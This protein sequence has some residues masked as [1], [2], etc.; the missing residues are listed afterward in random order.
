VTLQG[1]PVPVGSVD[2]QPTRAGQAE[3]TNLKV[4]QEHR[5]HGV[6]RM[7]INAALQSV[8]RQ[9]L[10]GARLEARPSDNSISLSSLVAMYQQMGFKGAGI[11]GRGNPVMERRTGSV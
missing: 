7:L 3:I 2:I 4:V 10:T 11:S 6:A 9:G 8:Q 5:R 1:S